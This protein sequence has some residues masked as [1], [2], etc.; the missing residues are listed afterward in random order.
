MKLI[1]TETYEITVLLLIIVFGALAHATAQLK[2]ARDSKLP[3]TFPDFI[4]LSFLGAFAGLMF[5]FLG[6]LSTENET[7][8]FLL[9]GM[10]SFLG[11]AGLNYLSTWV[12]N[13]FNIKNEAKDKDIL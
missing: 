3:F 7:L 2:I 4:I 12:L 5:L 13:K 6:K 1:T 11:V 8:L 10:G 9:T